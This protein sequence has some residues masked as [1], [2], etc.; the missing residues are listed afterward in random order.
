MGLFKNKVKED[1]AKIESLETLNSDLTDQIETLRAELVTS[2][3]S[4]ATLQTEVDELKASLANKEDKVEDLNE[5]LES[6]SDEQLELDVIVAEKT[7]EVVADA[8]LDEPLEVADEVITEKS[9]LETFAELKGSEKLKF[10]QD[11]KEAIV[12][13]AM[14]QK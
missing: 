4:A 7:A 6:A 8:G 2:Q 3:E 10:Y 9:A 13:L 1:T 14:L 12:K 5:Q 11:N